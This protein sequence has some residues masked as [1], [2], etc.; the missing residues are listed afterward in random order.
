LHKESLE[1]R[2]NKEIIEKTV[3]ELFKGKVKINFILSQ[4]SAIKKEED[5]PFIKSALETFKGRV[6]RED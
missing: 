6:I 2:E 5:A 1:R 4:E 3:S